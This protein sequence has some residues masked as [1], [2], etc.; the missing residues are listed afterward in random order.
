MLLSLMMEILVLMSLSWISILLSFILVEMCIHCFVLLHDFKQLLKD[1][2]HVWVTDQIIQVES[3]V[4]LS[5]VF[6]EIGFIN[7]FFD[8]EISQ[9]FDLIMVNHESFA[10]NGVIVKVLL[11]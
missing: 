3:T 4:L 11:R 10:I 5:H 9:L 8:L 2:S 7:C 1:L 6:L